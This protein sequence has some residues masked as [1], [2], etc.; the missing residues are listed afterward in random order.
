MSIFAHL[1]AIA[2]DATK[3]A[4]DTGLVRTD[5]PQR[6]KSSCTPCAAMARR[7]RAAAQVAQLTGRPPIGPVAIPPRKKVG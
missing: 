3:T 2:A 7:D 4:V 6:K 1:I 5:A